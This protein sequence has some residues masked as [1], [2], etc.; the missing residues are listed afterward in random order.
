MRQPLLVR[1]LYLG[2]DVHLNA[3]DPLDSQRHLCCHRSAH[4]RASGYAGTAG[5][6]FTGQAGQTFING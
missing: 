2:R 3:G 1:R 5:S 4:R 6:G